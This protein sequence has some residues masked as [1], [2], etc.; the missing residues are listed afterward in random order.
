MNAT[1]KRWNGARALQIDRGMSEMACSSSG[2]PRAYLG[3]ENR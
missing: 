1:P 2:S 3:F